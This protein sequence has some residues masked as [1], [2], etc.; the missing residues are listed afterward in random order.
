M[1]S[2]E[3][4]NKI[5]R[6]CELKTSLSNLKEIIGNC[7]D[8][9]TSCSSYV[10]DLIINNESIDKDVLTTSASGLSD[11]CSKIQQ[12]IVECDGKIDFYTLSYKLALAS[13]SI[14]NDVTRNSSDSSDTD[15]V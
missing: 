12:A 11:C 5:N 7:K 4:K 1:T 9:I 8:N 14:N 3:C 15:N 13:E 10:G 6:Y 2:A